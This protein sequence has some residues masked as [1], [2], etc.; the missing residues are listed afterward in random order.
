MKKGRFIMTTWNVDVAHSNVGFSVRHMMIS[1]VRGRFTKFE[2]AFKGNLDNFIDGKV[3]FGI[4]ASSIDTDNEDRDNHLRSDDFFDVEKY[5]HITFASTDIVITG[6]NKYD[7]I[8]EMTIKDVTK[9]ITFK[10]EY[11]GKGKNPWG[12]DVG[13]FE[14]TTK[15]SRKEFGLTWNQTLEA[16]GVLV[17]DDIKIDI[18]VQVNPG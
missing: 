17:G 8:G 7:I 3:N 6:E 18:E 4:D 10:A 9:N 13:A 5:P 14:A 11:L 16:G 2:G 12:V 15:I 1:K